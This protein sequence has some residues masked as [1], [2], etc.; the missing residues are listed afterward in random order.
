VLGEP[1]VATL[2][3]RGEFD[4]SAAHETARA[5][6]W[7]GGAIWTVAAVRQLVPVFYALGDTRTPVIVSAID[8][9]A[10]I[11]IALGLRGTMG[12]VGI[13]A[14]VA[15]SSF[16]QMALLFVFLQR[17]LGTSMAGEIGGSALRTLAA[18]AVGAAAGFFAAR[19]VNGTLLPGL[20]A[21]TAFC[22]GFVVAGFGFR[23]PELQSMA[24]V[25]QRRVAG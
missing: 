20:F 6:V 8:L 15:G 24:R 7:Q 16:V 21:G 1:L 3:Q 18:S 25:V 11:A 2:F 9:C 5:L 14:A 17:K 23:S 10:F 22:V 12:H 4:R 13:S 19:A